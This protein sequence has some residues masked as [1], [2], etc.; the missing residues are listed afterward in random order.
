[1]IKSRSLPRFILNDEQKKILPPIIWRSRRGEADVRLDIVE[2]GLGTLRATHSMQIHKD[3]FFRFGNRDFFGS[4]LKSEKEGS[5]F[6]LDL[7]DWQDYGAYFDIYRL[8]AYPSLKSRYELPNEAGID[9]Y[10]RANYLARSDVSLD[11]SSGEI[12]KT[13][14]LIQDGVHNTNVDYYIMDNQGVPT[15]SSG[16]ALTHFSNETPMW[17][18]H[19]L[20][21]VKEPTLVSLSGVLYTWRAEYLAGRIEIL[22]NVPFCESV[23][24]EDL[25]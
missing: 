5:V 7:K 9:L 10:R 6:I 23:G 25:R 18:F 1:L 14:D 11:Q 13:W 17:S 16:L 20:C 21:A 4:I 19:Q 24:R 12:L 22:G 15:G 3:G 8:I 2:I